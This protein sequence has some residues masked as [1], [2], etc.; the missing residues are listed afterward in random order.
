MLALLAL[1]L[2]AGWQMSGY[3]MAMYLA[4]LRGMGLADTTEVRFHPFE[5]NPHLA[6]G[7]QHLGEHLAADRRQ[8][9]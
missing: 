5:L 1:V 7:G 9:R 8:H 2:A 3:T 6:A 4:G